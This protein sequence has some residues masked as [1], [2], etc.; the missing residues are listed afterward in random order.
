[1]KVLDY[2]EYR[3]KSNALVVDV[4]GWRTCVSIC[5]SKKEGVEGRQPTG[6]VKFRS[7]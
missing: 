6:T 5:P 3:S 2:Q 4:P 7:Q 1:M